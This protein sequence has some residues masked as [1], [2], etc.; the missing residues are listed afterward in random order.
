MRVAFVGPGTVPPSRA[1]SRGE[2]PRPLELCDGVGQK[3][4]LLRVARS[5]GRGQDQPA[6][7]APRVLGQLRELGH[8]AE[9]V[10]LAEPAPADRTRVRVRERDDAVG[11]RLAL[12]S[13]L[14]LVGDLLAAVG[15][16]LEPRG[17]PERLPA[18]PGHAPGRACAEPTG[19]PPGPS[20]RAASRSRRSAS[21]PRP[22]PA[23]SGGGWCG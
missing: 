14:D 1:T 18:G 23:P 5:G 16:L 13:P 19:G 10:G 17:G 7:P 12:H 20:A 11:D 22:W 8:I 4:V 21:A 3:R 2:S 15:Q 6:R 9:I